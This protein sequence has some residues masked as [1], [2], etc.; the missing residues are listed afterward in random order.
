ME[1]DNINLEGRYDNHIHCCPHI[2]ARSL[3]LHDAVEDAEREKMI[4][5]GLMD[6]FSVTSGYASLMNS[7][8]RNFQ[9]KVFGGL[10]MEPYT[11]GVNPENLQALMKYSYGDF[12]QV[13]KFV[14]FPTH[15]T[16]F[17]AKQEKRNDEYVNSCFSLNDL[18]KVNKDVLKILDIIANNKLVLNT[19]HLSDVESINLINLAKNHGI[20][21]IL[22]PANHL[23]KETLIEINSV[24]K[25]F[26]EFSYF[27]ISEA[28]RIPLTHIDGEKHIIH[29]LE[30]KKLSELIQAAKTENIILSSDCG[31][32]VLPRPVDGLKIFIYEILKLG[33]TIRDIDRMTKTN[34][35][36]LFY[37]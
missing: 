34:P 1:L 4:A 9:V 3:N 28:T 13:F 14:S 11:G 21:K 32:S 15:H 10:I 12:D 29:G 7:I 26:F 17:V 35:Q 2:N 24:T 16:Q 22:V 5:I 19:G 25:V 36:K 30:K 31:V 37:E 27:F 8:F 33:F 23:A 6:N 20:K 18:K